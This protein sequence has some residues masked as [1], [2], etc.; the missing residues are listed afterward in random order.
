MS[1]KMGITIYSLNRVLSFTFNKVSLFPGVRCV[2][3]IDYWSLGAHVKYL[4]THGGTCAG[5]RLS[6]HF[7]P[8]LSHRAAGVSFQCRIS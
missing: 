7:N 6:E 2:L 3:M 8:P 1:N 4:L 5:S